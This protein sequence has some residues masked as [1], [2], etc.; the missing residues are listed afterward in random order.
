MLKNII[1]CNFIFSVDVWLIDDHICIMKE[2]KVNKIKAIVNGMVL[3][4]M[5]LPLANAVA[6]NGEEQFLVSDRPVANETLQRCIDDAVDRMSKVDVNTSDID[7]LTCFLRDDGK[8]SGIFDGLEKY[9][10]IR[11]LSLEVRQRDEGIDRVIDFSP[12]SN[13][14]HLDTAY[15]DIAFPA[16]FSGLAN[17]PDIRVLSVLTRSDEPL[18]SFDGIEKLHNLE[19]LSLQSDV[20]FASL[21][22]IS[23]LTQLEFLL[24]NG[25]NVSDISALSGMVNLTSFFASKNQISDLS[26]LA[27]LSKLE[28]LSLGSNRVSDLSPIENLPA[29]DHLVLFNNP[30]SQ[31]SVSGLPDNLSSFIQDFDD[32]PV[33]QDNCP[34]I[35][36]PGQW[37]KDKDGIGN[38]CDLDID[39]DGC[40]NDIEDALGT[41]KWNKDSVPAVCEIPDTTASDSDSDND[42][43]VDSADNCPQIANPGQWDKDKD[44][45]GNECDLD[46]DGDMCA[47]DIEIAL[48]FKAWNQNSVPE[49]CEIP[50]GN[51]SD[52]DGIVDSV[53]NCVN[54]ANPGQWDKDDDDIGNECDDDIDGDGFTN[55]QE[56]DHGTKEWNANSFPDI[57]VADIHEVS[58]NGDKLVAGSGEQAGFALYVFD[59]DLGQVG[60]VCNDECEDHWPPLL[61]A[62]NEASG[63]ADLSSI[64]RD[65]GSEQVTYK[66]RPLY[67]FAGD[68]AVG[69]ENGQS[70]GK[71]WWIAEE[72]Q[73]V[74]PIDE[75]VLQEGKLVAGSREQ[76]GFALYVF[77][78]DL[79]I[80]GSV[81]NDECEDHWPPLLVAD[82]Q[83]SGLAHL[84]SVIRDD[85]SEQVA[86]KGRPLYFFAG[87]TA[88]GD[89]NGQ[90]LGKVWWI[91]EENQ[92]EPPVDEVALNKEF[93]VVAEGDKAGFSLYFF[94]NDLNRD[95]S[96]CN[97][98]CA[99]TWPPLLLADAQAS[100]LSDDSELGSITR[101]DGTEQVTYKERPVY[102]FAGDSQ[103]GDQ[104]G[105]GI[106]GVWWLAE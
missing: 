25:S 96:V 53:D 55:Q 28:V 94:D 98:G 45:I 29:L 75:V 82:A 11:N 91:A 87:D 50:V 17:I 32:I 61:V 69:D 36:N 10:N 46:I 97:D 62:D 105:Q 102:L 27:N 18:S 104:N 101:D 99:A 23:E 1:S 13:I 16:D 81:C 103:A 90:G 88:A 43:I 76:A 60:S 5:C 39:G 68:I 64:I 106:G 24:I 38:E 22:F 8:G 48:G 31:E 95:G 78:K 33:Q 84:S 51:D 92:P 52:N 74:P 34:T 80:D 57:A 20:G 58:F 15:I 35:T 30:L 72:N 86:Y 83:A 47:N 71:V 56:R 26:A 9:K 73:P 44:G 14:T 93:L 79:G 2:D 66:G 54:I 100:G 6:A 42:G 12:L 37:D 70:L 77:D 59:K 65:D 49:V 67:F 63:I 41:K 40:A 19:S 89:E 85:G 4:G 7:S 3:A 21:D